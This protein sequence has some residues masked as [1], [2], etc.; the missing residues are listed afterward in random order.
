MGGGA[1]KPMKKEASTWRTAGKA[2]EYFLNFPP[3][4]YVVSI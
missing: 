1:G 3:D 4:S 2:E